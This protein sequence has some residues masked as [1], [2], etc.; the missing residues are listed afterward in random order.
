MRE[1]LAEI[2]PDPDVQDE[3]DKMERYAV[4]E[5]MKLFLSGLEKRET[6][7]RGLYIRA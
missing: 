4:T 5:S 1:A 2:V 3:E 6:R 7:V